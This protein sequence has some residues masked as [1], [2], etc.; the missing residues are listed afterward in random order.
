MK[1][2]FQ[3]EVEIGDTVAYIHDDW[4][5]KYELKKGEVTKITSCFIHI[6]RRKKK[7]SHC[8]KVLDNTT[9]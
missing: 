2:Q 1:D 3:N 9:K 6:D 8:I 5:G 4:G 7:P